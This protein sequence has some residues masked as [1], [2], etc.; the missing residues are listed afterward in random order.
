M[1]EKQATMKESLLKKLGQNEVLPLLL[2]FVLFVIV[3]SIINLRFISWMNI[4]NVLVQVS[5]TGMMTLGTFMVILLGGIDLSIGQLTNVL[6]CGMAFLI[7]RGWAIPL[8]ILLFVL[9]ALLLE[10]VMG[11]IIASTKIEP[12]IISLGFMSIYQGITYLI[13]NGSEIGIPGYFETLGRTFPFGDNMPAMPVYILIALTILVFL[14]LKY[15]VYGR[16]IY[17]IGSNQEAAVLAGINVKLMKISVYV[18]NGL[19]VSLAAM[20]LLSRLATGNPTMGSGKELDAIAGAVIGGTAMTGGRG[21]VIGVFIGILLLGCISNSMNIIGVSPY[22][23]YA[24]RG[25]I[26]VVAV[27]IGDLSQRRASLGRG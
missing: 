15:T 20:T 16:R 26:I 12:F 22:W 7:Y 11:T 18:V 13:T 1:N 21:N 10:G 24:L 4:K 5:V 14:M 19:L 8:V 27:V 2:V 9:L 25:I 3:I 23:Q 17:A 6:G